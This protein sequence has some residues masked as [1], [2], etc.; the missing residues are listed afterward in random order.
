[1][2]THRVHRTTPELFHWPRKRAI[3]P[4]RICEVIGETDR[5]RECS[6][7]EPARP[8]TIQ[9]IRACLAVHC[10]RLRLA[11]A[12]LEDLVPRHFANVYFVVSSGYWLI[13]KYT[14]R[15]AHQSCATLGADSGLVAMRL[16]TQ[17][18]F[19][20]VSME[21]FGPWGGG[22]WRDVL[23]S[24]FVPSE[25]SLAAPG[26][27]PGADAQ[28]SYAYVGCDGEGRSVY[29]LSRQRPCGFS[30]ACRGRRIDS[31]FRFFDSLN[32]RD[33]RVSIVPFSS[34]QAVRGRESATLHL[35]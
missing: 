6:D 3:G 10:N 29:E 28:S 32:C 30:Q 1:V 11:P 20:T 25:I 22:G 5:Q 26:D 33:M 16:T 35:E 9:F 34:P 31:V 23:T 27:V 18:C 19:Q 17:H 7:Q 24:R 15:Y 12:E 21:N 13:G 14:M 4:A 2:S 8:A